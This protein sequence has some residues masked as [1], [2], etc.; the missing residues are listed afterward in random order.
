MAMKAFF[1]MFGNKKYVAALSSP[2]KIRRR[3]VL[4]KRGIEERETA[5]L[6]RETPMQKESS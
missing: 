2:L 6:R 5:K 1:I 3:P 4:E